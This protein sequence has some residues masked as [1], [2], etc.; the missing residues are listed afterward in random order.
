[1]ENAV[2]NKLVI[3][4][5]KPEKLKKEADK[6][7]AEKQLADY[8]MQLQKEDRSEYQGVLT[9]GI[10]IKYL[11]YQ[12]GRIHATSYKN[13]DEDDLDKLVQSLSDITNKKFVPENIVEDFKIDSTKSDI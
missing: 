2:C 6:K 4:Y 5:K 12:D 9:D 10:K 13:I 8:L 3:E 1:M 7:K 11:Y